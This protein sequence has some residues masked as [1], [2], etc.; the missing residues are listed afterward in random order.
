MLTINEQDK[1]IVQITEHDKLTVQEWTALYE[2][3]KTDKNPDTNALRK[4]LEAPYTKTFNN[5]EREQYHHQYMRALR[6]K[7]EALTHEPSPI[8]KTMTRSQLYSTDSPLWALDMRPRDIIEIIDAVAW[9]KQYGT[10]RQILNMFDDII[11]FN[12][13][14]NYP[15]LNDLY[16]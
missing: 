14:V 1:L 15:R 4:F 9:L 2:S 5:P 16:H 7:L 11:D 12:G 3:F 8:E 10:E 6:I 13:K